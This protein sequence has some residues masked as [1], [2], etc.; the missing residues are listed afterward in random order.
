M[1]YQLSHWSLKDLFSGFDSPDLEA[2]FKKLEQ[3]SA[4]FE[5]W[6]KQLKPDL[7]VSDFLEIMQD[8]E[9]ITRNLYILS[10]YAELAFSADTQSQ[11]AQNL[12]GRIQQFKAEL[13]NS[14]MFF[15]L[16]WKNLDIADV[17]RLMEASGDVRY[18]LEAMRKFKP[19]TLS[20][21]EEQVVNLKNVTGS[22]A[23]V[24]LYSAITNR[25]LFKIEVNGETRELAY[26]ELKVLARSAD[27]DLR[28]RAYQELFR[29]YSAE[30][31]ILGQMYQTR[32]RD[33]HNENI[34]IRKFA[35]PIAARNLRN[36][37]PDE[38][39]DA[40]LNVCKRNVL[41]FQRF[42]RLKAR[43]LGMDKLRRYDILAPVGKSEK[44]YAFDQAAGMVLDSFSSF[45]PDFGKLARR[46][47]D[48]NHLDSEIRKGKESG[49]FCA[50]VTAG[51]TPWVHLNYLGRADDVATMA[52]ELGHAIHAMLAGHH[53]VFTY[54][55]CLP[56]AE[57]AS[58]FGEMML[59]DKLLASETDQA[60]RGELLFRQMDDA[61]F[62]II[63]QA[64]FAIFEK[65]AH[66]MVLKNASVDEL[67]AAYLGNLK[68]QFGDAVEI[69]EE[70][71]WEWVSIPHFFHTPFYVYAYAFGQLL[72]LAL[73]QQYKAEGEAFK[74]RYI[75][76]LSAGGS[77]APARVCAEAGLDICSE[78]FWQG[79]FDVLNRL[80]EQL[81]QME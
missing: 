3:Q 42:F 79:G 51:M 4:G 57:T 34:A 24:T 30:A 61:Y 65:Q 7:P 67:A 26:E 17:Q 9:E 40:L 10:G 16:W 23:L 80:V 13:E 33:W 37:I 58:T 8:S 39:V 77:L 69:S 49:A 31:P 6:R 75:K 18:Y 62:T 52:H 12:L 71:R 45:H 11:S 60:V 36:D 41:V 70:F 72:V 81:E 29:L 35:S 46:V 38:A 66:A 20:E 64:F 22:N 44:I 1:A 2:A 53:S 50:Y 54:D 63:R 43:R 78:E 74:P 48:Q 73:Y 27:P 19:H 47:F 68:E 25:Y 14:T 76:M 15:T 59:V 56:L 55:A 21:P 28:A 5:H 32:V